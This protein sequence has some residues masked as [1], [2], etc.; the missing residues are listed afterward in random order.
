MTPGP[1]P[2]VDV[3]SEAN[4][5]KDN[6]TKMTDYQ[7]LM[8]EPNMSKRSYIGKW[9]DTIDE[10]EPPAAFTTTNT[11]NDRPAAPSQHQVLKSWLHKR[12][13]IT[14][15]STGPSGLSSVGPRPSHEILRVEMSSMRSSACLAEVSNSERC[16]PDMAKQVYPAVGNSN[17]ATPGHQTGYQSSASNRQDPAVDTIMAQ[18]PINMNLDMLSPANNQLHPIS[19]STN[20]SHPGIRGLIR[21][22][23][24]LEIHAKRLEFLS[25]AHRLEDEKWVRNRSQR[26]FREQ[27]L[28]WQ[29]VAATTR[30]QQLMSAV[31]GNHDIDYTRA[32]HELNESFEPIEQLGETL[33]CVP[34][35]R[36][37]KEKLHVEPIGK[38]HQQL[39]PPQRHL[40][41]AQSQF[42]KKVN[43]ESNDGISPRT[44]NVEDYHDQELRYPK[45]PHPYESMDL[46][47][48]LEL[49]EQRADDELECDDSSDSSTSQSTSEGTSPLGRGTPDLGSVVPDVNKE[50]RDKSSGHMQMPARESQNQ[51]NRRTSPSSGST[52]HR[53]V[54]QLLQDAFNDPDAGLAEIHDAL[55]R[56]LKTDDH[57]DTEEI[58]VVRLVARQSL[59]FQN[60]LN[61]Q[62]KQT[63]ALL[64]QQNMRHRMEL[65]SVTN[66][67][68]QT[69]SYHG[70][71]GNCTTS[72]G[73]TQVRVVL[74]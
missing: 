70:D 18:A 10:A 13:S 68:K 59:T 53:A 39:F 15:V 8:A 60:L 25:S 58:R 42:Q 19:L 47:G 56:F 24:L 50:D 45:Q 41:Q 36:R 61:L 69:I 20:P 1:E 11:A 54:L 49:P 31:E 27:A 51:V 35:A 52:N 22:Q 65:S 23:K 63:Q 33:C 64:Q 48:E 32:V 72:A 3:K 7:R 16:N 2:I 29:I 21:V 46:D 57:H 12:K 44:V 17:V 38:Q 9:L 37:I 5:N 30:S 67:L 73:T 26:K 4:I 55:E 43:K 14:D 71:S 40:Q 74:P 66:N 62:A 28:K 34:G 6:S